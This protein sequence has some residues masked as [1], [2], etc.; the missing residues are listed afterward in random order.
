MACMRIETFT[1]EDVLR[2]GTRMA[3]G[4]SR[5]NA[6]S[7]D[8]RKVFKHDA[9]SGLYVADRDYQWRRVLADSEGSRTRKGVFYSFDVVEAAVRF[10][11]RDSNRFFIFL[12]G[13][14]DFGY[15]PMSSQSSVNLPFQIL[16]QLQEEGR[17]TYENR[18]LRAAGA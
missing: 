4:F 17:L 6:G 2:L 9:I 14:G 1:L 5:D 7:L 15:I 12:H 13:S 16:C 18:L 10:I 8:L 11:G 3:P